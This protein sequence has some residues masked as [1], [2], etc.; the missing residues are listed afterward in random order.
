MAIA[1][2]LKDA[3]QI[4][5]ADFDVLERLVETPTIMLNMHKLLFVNAGFRQ[6]FDCE[7]QMLSLKCLLSIIHTDY[8][9]HFET[10]LDC[11][12]SG[13]TYVDHGE[14][15]VKTKNSK[16]FW[17]TYTL[18][19][20]TYNGLPHALIQLYENN[21]KKRTDTYKERLI[22]LS[23]SILEVTHSIV[24][25]DGI[26]ELY[27]VIMQ[28]AVNAISNA[29]HGSIMKLEGDFLIP[30]AHIGFETNA[31]RRV[32][33]PL[34]THILYKVVGEK[35]DQIIKV[36]DLK[37]IET[38]SVMHSALSAPIYIKGKFFGVV[39]VE[40]KRMDSFDDDDVN[41]MAFFR[42]N[43]E[44]AIT[45]QY[46]NEEK[47]F[48]SRFDSLTSLYNRNYFDE[49]YELIKERAQRYH[50]NFNLVVF[51]LNDLKGTNDAYGHMAG[52]LL[53]KH[54]ATTCKNLIRKSDVLARYGGDEFVGLFFNC[55]QGKLR[56]KIDGHLKYLNENPIFYKNKTIICSYSYGIAQF[57]EDGTTLGELF[58]V[59]DD[60]M[61]ENK[62]RYKLGFDFIEMFEPSRRNTF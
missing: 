32:K 53:L 33:I 49:V 13:K 60:R 48:L 39:T 42:N 14:L 12:L 3:I 57:N 38:D 62:M 31:I 10:M 35:L 8:L 59:A 34:K 24:N 26:N 29:S 28:C 46:L 58:K 30:V 6:H 41:L 21:E 11:A 23:E 2:D 40:S 51:D 36:N 27:R 9:S 50:E 20:V 17:M 4:N 5:D 54:F 61:Y 52:D 37:T 25:A 16:A 55:S 1:Y 22:K 47:S 43:L 15:C 19:V 18:R 45:N 7:G 44:I 56:K